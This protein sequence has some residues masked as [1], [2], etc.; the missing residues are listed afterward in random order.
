MGCGPG[1]GPLS[2]LIV[3][4]LGCFGNEPISL[5][6]PVLGYA[7]LDGVPCWYCPACCLC[8]F[9]SP[10]HAQVSNSRLCPWVWVPLISHDFARSAA[11][12]KLLCSVR[13]KGAG[14]VLST[15]VPGVF[16]RARSL[17]GGYLMIVGHR[18]EWPQRPAGVKSQPEKVFLA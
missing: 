11:Y 16:L 14:S 12:R 6:A 3:I 2:S 4:P 18:G 13:L 1:L 8:P 7:F 17:R 5:L 10:S 15:A 9:E